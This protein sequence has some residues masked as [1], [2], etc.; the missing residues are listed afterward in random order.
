[1]NLARLSESGE[2]YYLRTID[3]QG[4]TALDVPGVYA[5]SGTPGT[6]LL[7]TCSGNVIGGY[8]TTALRFPGW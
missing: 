7:P 6:A 4:S 5:G 2:C 3:R 8:A 1:V